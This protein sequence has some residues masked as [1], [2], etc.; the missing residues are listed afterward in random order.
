[1][2]N[3]EAI[4]AA[5]YKDRHPATQHLLDILRPNPRLDGIAADVAQLFWEAAQDSAELLRDGPELTAGLRKLREAK[6]CF[7][8]QAVLDSRQ[9]KFEAIK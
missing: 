3:E 8:M 6:D 7:V 5:K 9:P 4:Q 1:V 2:S